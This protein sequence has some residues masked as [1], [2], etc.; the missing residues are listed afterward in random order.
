[1]QQIKRNVN[2]LSIIGELT[3]RKGN[4]FCSRIF[5]F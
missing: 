4:A 3:L 5:E 1:M 2:V